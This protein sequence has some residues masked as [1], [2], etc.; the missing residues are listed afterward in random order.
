MQSRNKERGSAWREVSDNIN[1]LK[2][3]G[4]KTTH[5][6]VREKFEKMLKDYKK[7]ENEEKRASGVD[8]EYSEIDKAL[9]DINGRIAEVVEAQ[10]RKREKVNIEKLK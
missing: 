1:A 9:E 10:E 4:F 3:L 2:E 8:V 5:R 6:F 7:K